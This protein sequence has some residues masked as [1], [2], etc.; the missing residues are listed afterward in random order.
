MA[1]KTEKS[2]GKVKEAVGSLTG[3]KKLESEGKID[4]RA[5]ET[6]EKIGRVKGKVEGVVEKAERK[7]TKAVDKAKDAARRK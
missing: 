4:R 1:G 3:N 6:K 5:G 7:A 2:K